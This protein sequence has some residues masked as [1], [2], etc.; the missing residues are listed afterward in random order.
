MWNYSITDK[1]LENGNTKVT[2]NYTDGV[3]TFSKTYSPP[4]L[5][6]LKDTIRAELTALEERQSFISALPS[7]GTIDLTATP[8]VKEKADREA[9]FSLLSK[10]VNVNRDIELG[11]ITAQDPLI[12][13]LQADLEA[14]YKPE[15]SLNP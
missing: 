10:R 4:S 9:Y 7:N 8:P 15:Y 14:A 6:A 5:E 1:K 3:T 13:Q 12:V 11:L 2:I